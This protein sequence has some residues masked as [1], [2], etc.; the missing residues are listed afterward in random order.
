M[1]LGL[2]GLNLRVFYILYVFFVSPYFY[3]DA[4]MHHTMHVLDAPAVMY[5]VPHVLCKN[6][7]ALGNVLSNVVLCPILTKTKSMAIGK[8]HEELQ[9]RLGTGVLEQVTRVVYPGGLLTEDGRCE[10]E[11]KRRIVLACVAFGGLGKMWREKSISIATKM[12]LYDALLVPVLL[13]GS[14]CWSLR[15]EDERR[16]LVAEMSWL[17]RIIGRSRREKVRNE[18]TREELG[19]EETVVQKIKGRRLQWFGHVER[20]EEKRLPNAALHGHVEGK[21]SRGRER[22]T[23]MDNVREDLKE[24]NIDLTRIGEATRNREVWRNLVR[25]SSSAR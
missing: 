15:K 21:R 16:L 7:C 13:Y 1:E 2:K 4:F 20:M 14:E 17:K 22:K 12:K 19:A 25:A 3:H 9:V 23:W 18:Q 24:R 6:D 5:A 11:V 8:Q 10:E